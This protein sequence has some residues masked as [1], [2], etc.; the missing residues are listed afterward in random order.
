MK[1][2][3]FIDNWDSKIFDALVIAEISFP[4]L[5]SYGSGNL[6]NVI[7]YKELRWIE[8]PEYKSRKLGS[9]PCKGIILLFFQYGLQ[10]HFSMS[11][12]H[13]E[14]NTENVKFSKGRWS[15]SAFSCNILLRFISF[16]HLLCTTSIRTYWLTTSHDSHWGKAVLK[17]QKNSLIRNE[18]QSVVFLTRFR[19]SC[20]LCGALFAVVLIIIDVCLSVNFLMQRWPATR[21]QISMGR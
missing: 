21:L 11:T 10:Q 6:K 7:F 4:D 20:S 12:N 5:K 14:R 19:I 3:H 8:I 17:N 15:A 2:H 16:C 1:V 18:C 13:A 9:N